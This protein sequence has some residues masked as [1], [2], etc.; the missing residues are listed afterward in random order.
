VETKI[1]LVGHPIHPM[2]VVLPLGLLSIGL[3]CDVI[4]LVGGDRTFANVAFW[5]I[6]FGILGGLAAAIFGLAD[7]L[8]IPSDTR[9][10]RIGAMH[11]IGNLIIVVLF[12]ISWILRL[13]DHAYAPNL[14][15]FIL[16]LIGVILALG[17]QWL[18]GEL[19]FRLRIGVDDIANANATSSLTGEPSRS[20]DRTARVS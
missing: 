17:T 19:V 8:Q 16:A 20:R 14:V 9:A 13:A 1:K 11:G 7:W 2:L 3:L 10:K 12:I 4:Y 15:P 5:D 18:G 6:T